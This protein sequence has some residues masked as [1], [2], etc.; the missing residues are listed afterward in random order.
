MEPA[1]AG[2]DTPAVHMGYQWLFL[3]FP[4]V[5]FLAWWAFYRN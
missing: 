3:L 5:G 2:F 1:G 4:L